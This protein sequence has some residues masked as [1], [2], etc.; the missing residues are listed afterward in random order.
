MLNDMI[1]LFWRRTIGSASAGSYYSLW[2]CAAG[3]MLVL[4]GAVSAV[5]DSWL[6]WIGLTLML[7]LLLIGGIVLLAIGTRDA[8]RNFRRF[9]RL[10]SEKKGHA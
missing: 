9:L 1:R 8:I 5:G 7:I 3:A 6:A 4:W 2:I 10:R